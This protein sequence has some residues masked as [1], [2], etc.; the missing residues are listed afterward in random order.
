MLKERISFHGL[1]VVIV[2]A[3]MCTSDVYYYKR[4]WST[5]KLQE[6]RY[7]KRTGSII[8]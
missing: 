3:I 6:F 8:V 2:F 4:I 5:M 1:P 7:E